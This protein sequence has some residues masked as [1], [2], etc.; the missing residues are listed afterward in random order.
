MG[1]VTITGL[2]EGTWPMEEI[3]CFTTNVS[4]SGPC[5]QLHNMTTGGF[6][7]SLSYGTMLGMELYASITD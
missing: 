2:L 6:H 7:G 4:F 3:L 1:L 5:I